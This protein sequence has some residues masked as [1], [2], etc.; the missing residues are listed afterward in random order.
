MSP[1]AQHTS[2]KA[3]ESDWELYKPGQTGD[4]Q[5]LCQN[6]VNSLEDWFHESGKGPRRR[7]Y[8]CLP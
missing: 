4:R 5:E 8:R 2:S 1:V 3:Q 6:Q 7:V